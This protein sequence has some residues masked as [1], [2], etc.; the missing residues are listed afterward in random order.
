MDAPST[1]F[2]A[3]LNCCPGCGSQVGIGPS[4]PLGDFPCP[5]CGRLLWFL[6]RLEGEVVVFTF[7]PRSAVDRGT[8]EQV[9][10]VVSAVGDVHR[11]VVNLSHLRLVSAF[12]LGMLVRLHLRMETAHVALKVCGLSRE[13][14]EVFKVTKLD[15]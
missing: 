8:V 4:A 14:A 9:D 3:V 10:D 6:Q 12:F 1:S 13:S 2:Q 7:L 15:S 5:Q 11:V